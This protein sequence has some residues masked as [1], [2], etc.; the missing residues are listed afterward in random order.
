MTQKSLTVHCCRKRFK[1]LAEEVVFADAGWLKKC[2]LPRRES[3]RGQRV[4]QICQNWLESVR[5]EQKWIKNV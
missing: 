5:N 2:V 1:G 3:K 4:V